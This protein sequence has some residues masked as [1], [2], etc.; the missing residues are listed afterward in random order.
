[1]RVG[2]SPGELIAAFTAPMAAAVASDVR[3]NLP[4]G[5]LTAASDSSDSEPLVE[6][7]AEE[8]EEEEAN[9]GE[10]GRSPASPV[11][12]SDFKRSRTMAEA[13]CSATS[14]PAGR[15]SKVMWR[16]RTSRRGRSTVR[17]LERKL[18]GREG[19]GEDEVQ[20]GVQ[21]CLL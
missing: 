15:K 17:S 20:K 16:G 11:N 7:E 3:E 6:A 21:Q 19:K 4:A 8:E 10:G 5:E 12:V 1:M 2:T 9:G 14:S 18:H 13:M